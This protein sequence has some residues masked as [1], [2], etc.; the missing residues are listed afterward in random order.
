[1][2]KVYFS[3]TLRL[4]PSE[5][6]LK[7]LKKGSRV[8][9]GTVLGRVGKVQTGPGSK[10]APHLNFSIRPAGRG[11]PRIDPKPILDGWK[12]LEATRDLPRRRPEPVRRPTRASARCC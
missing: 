4:K 10:L 6:K 1:M 3:K 9:G 12:L 2:F 11:A 5:V 7:T 8:I